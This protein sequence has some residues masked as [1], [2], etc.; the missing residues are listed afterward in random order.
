[1][2]ISA[3]RRD[4]IADLAEQIAD[5]NLSS[6]GV[7]AEAIARAKK[8][9]ISYGHYQDS[10]D[11]L[12]EHRSGRFHIYCNLDR[13]TRMDNPRTRFT[14]GHELGH[15]FIVEHCLALRSGR[16]PGHGSFTEYESQNPVEQEADHFASNL[17]MPRKHF[18]RFA[19]REPNGI[20]GILA[21]ARR[22]GTSLTSTAIR[23]A[24]LEV[25]PCFVVKW[26]AEGFQWKWLSSRT[27]LANLR[28]TI[29][30]L[31]R[32]VPGS[33][34]ARALAGERPPAV[35]VFPNWNHG[36]YLV[37]ICRPGGKARCDTC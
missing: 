2:S 29:E 12:L 37:P 7:D 35:R 36:I 21:L 27:R 13:L 19:Q 3:T 10:F 8:I 1:M 26:S 22:F 5:Q 33:A 30:D 32:I 18:F 25:Q 34:T 11:G 28:K 4:E 14:L 16:S 24:S 31:T 17:L 23:Y 6:T 20:P 9:T 15:F